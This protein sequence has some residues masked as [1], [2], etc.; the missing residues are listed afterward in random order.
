MAPPDEVFS[1]ASFAPAA[2]H[3]PL[4][5][6]KSPI[7]QSRSALPTVTQ[8]PNAASGLPG[9]GATPTGLGQALPQGKRG[10]TGGWLSARGNTEMS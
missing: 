4:M 10:L 5:R 2:L 8:N 6:Q 1:S 9:A 7:L 3:A